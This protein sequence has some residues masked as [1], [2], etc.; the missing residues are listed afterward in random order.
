LAA[1]P[2]ENATKINERSELSQWSSQW[3]S[4]PGQW[5]GIQFSLHQSK[6]MIQTSECAFP[7]GQVLILAFDS[8]NSKAERIT[9]PAF[10]NVACSPAFDN[11]DKHTYHPRY[12]GKY[13]C[14]PAFDIVDKHTYH[15]RYFGKYACSPAFDN[16]DKH[17]YH[18]RYFW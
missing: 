15:P 7:D 11:V 1:D 6:A 16:V 3:S 10:D 5:V 4:D 18:P 8:A 17:P 13:A 2:H 14:S 9:C 12:I